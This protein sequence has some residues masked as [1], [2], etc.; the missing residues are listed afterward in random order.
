MFT[1]HRPHATSAPV[2]GAAVAWGLSGSV[3]P[4]V[5]APAVRVVAHPVQ[6]RAATY[7]PVRS[8]CG[9]RWTRVAR[10]A[11]EEITA[12]AILDHV[13]LGGSAALGAEDDVASVC[14]FGVNE[15][16]PRARLHANNGCTSLRLFK[17]PLVHSV[18]PS[19]SLCIVQGKQTRTA[20]TRKSSINSPRFVS[21]PLSILVSLCPV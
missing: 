20:F 8:S 18:L 1:A 9:T 14:S 15:R 13:A 17:I 11:L 3:E 19:Y 16:S 21:S 6:P 7:P 10:K 12:D 2:D 5:F 4:P